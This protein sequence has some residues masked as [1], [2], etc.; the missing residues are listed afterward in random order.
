[1]E[2]DISW[3]GPDGALERVISTGTL[4][5]REMGFVED[6]SLW[7]LG[8]EQRDAG[9]GQRRGVLHQYDASGKVIYKTAWIER[10]S[11]WMPASFP[12]ARLYTSR[13]H[14]AFTSHKAGRWHVM[15]RGPL[16]QNWISGKSTGFLN[17]PEGFEFSSGAV[18]DSGR[19]FVQGFWTGGSDDNRDSA[20]RDQDV[21]ELVRQRSRS[22]PAERKIEKVSD[23]VFGEPPPNEIHLVGSQGEDLV[24]TLRSPGRDTRVVQIP[25]N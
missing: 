18:T 17:V 22:Q 11:I 14:F 13:N 1:M 19:L 8:R 16:E 6:G 2:S 4:P 24:F 20:F 25:V 3:Y 15:W 9:D 10:P 23:K 21:F 12:D 7:C 5:V